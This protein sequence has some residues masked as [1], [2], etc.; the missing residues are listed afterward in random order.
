MQSGGGDR[1]QILRLGFNTLLFSLRPVASNRFHSVGLLVWEEESVKF[2][3][4][5]RRRKCPE[6]STE[7]ECLKKLGEIK[8]ENTESKKKRW[9]EIIKKILNPAW[10]EEFMVL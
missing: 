6:C 1:K 3:P 10:L 4:W 2:I 8:I 7:M 9:K 5:N